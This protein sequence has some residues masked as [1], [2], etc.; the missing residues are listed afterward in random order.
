M[1][2]DEMGIILFLGGGDCGLLDNIISVFLE[3]AIVKLR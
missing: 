3:K 2:V 1:S